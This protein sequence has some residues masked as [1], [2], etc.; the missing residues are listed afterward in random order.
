[1]AKALTMVHDL[2]P[3]VLIQ[4]QVAQY[5]DGLVIPPYRFIAAIYKKPER[6]QFKGGGSLI[7]PETADSRKEDSYQGKIGLIL[8]MG[9]GCFEDDEQRKWHGVAP[10]VG[11]WIVWNVGDTWRFTLGETECRWLSEDN[12]RM[13]SPSPDW[14]Y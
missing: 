6:I 12:W 9:P 14:F 3:K 1:M 13:T 8:K 11:D 4:E 2:D 10:K 7:V 5:L